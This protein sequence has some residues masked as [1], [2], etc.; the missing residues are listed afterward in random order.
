MVTPIAPVSSV[1]QHQPVTP[2]SANQQNIYEHVATTIQSMPH[3]ASPV[4]I[5]RSLGTTFK[6]VADRLE[7]GR[8]EVQ[9]FLASGDVGA[10]PAGQA[11]DQQSPLNK[12]KMS[13]LIQGLTMSFDL[14]QRQHMIANVPI[15]LTTSVRETTRG[16]G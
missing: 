11:K 8:V 15:Q 10:T 2:V 4:D 7:S 1:S 3:G 13:N 5:G 14:M 9:R 6:S 12:D 16:G